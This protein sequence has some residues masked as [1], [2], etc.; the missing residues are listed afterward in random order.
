VLLLSRFTGSAEE[1]EGAVLINP[2]NVDG[3][4]AAIRTALE[5]PADER[6]RRMR[7]MRRM[8][9]QLH[10]ST[11]FDWLDSILARSSEI[12]ADQASDHAAVC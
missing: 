3:F 5:M 11:I 7:R 10:N 6:R 8:R 2:F 9:Q 12:M 4:V 1:I